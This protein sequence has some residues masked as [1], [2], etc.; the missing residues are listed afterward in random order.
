MKIA[1]ISG[2]YEIAITNLQAVYTENLKDDLLSRRC[3]ELNPRLDCSC[4]N[5]LE[6]LKNSIAIEEEKTLFTLEREEKNIILKFSNKIN[7]KIPFNWKF[8][9]LRC[10][11]SN[12]ATRDL[13]TRPLVATL[14]S[15]IVE[16]NKLK[17]L[18]IKKDLEIKDYK[19][20]GGKVSRSFLETKSFNSD[21]FKDTLYSSPECVV[22]IN[23]P[24]YKTLTNTSIN[25][26]ISRTLKALQN[27]ELIKKKSSESDVQ[28]L[29]DS[30][31]KVTKI[32][33]SKPL[34][35]KCILDDYVEEEHV[36]DIVSTKEKKK[37][38]EE[39]MT[40]KKYLKKK[41]KNLL[42]N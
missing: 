25:N 31:N 19:D 17:E 4:L 32:T 16:N 15:L 6:H 39:V 36:T 2:G 14:N 22:L 37:N 20:H 30:P 1:F 10:E 34:K 27:G 28:S 9:F 13:L 38:I 3:V 8:I 18:L 29:T 33:F 7:K 42:L 35:R 41:K 23:R 40:S 11:S 12:T 24:C 26:E 21:A 5:T